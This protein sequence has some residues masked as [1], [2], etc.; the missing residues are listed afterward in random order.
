[1]PGAAATPT[2]PAALLDGRAVTWDQLRA[3]LVEAAGGQVLSEL[4]LNRRVAQRLAERGLILTDAQL[5]AERTILIEA[6]SADPDQA[7][8]LL[9]GLRQRRGWGPVRFAEMLRRNAGL[10]LLIQEQVTVHPATVDE[11]YQIEHGPK[12][13][14]RLIVVSTL[15]DAT[16]VMQRV[17]AGASFAELA[18][19]RSRDDSKDRGGLLSPLSVADP[20]YPSALRAAAGNLAVGQVSDPV[21]LDQGYAILKLERKIAADGVRFEDV[22]SA[23]TVR[24]RH[25]VEQMLIRRLAR[26]LLDQADLTIFDPQLDAGWVQQKKLLSPQ[27]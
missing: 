17:H 23:L 24:V 19:G 11:A 2:G 7:Q 9:T 25:R 6:L 18:A 10:R 21:A 13:E 15:A 3:P 16:D 20:T 5:A 14:L 22:K 4:V 1:V 12:L 8:R 27:P 26:E